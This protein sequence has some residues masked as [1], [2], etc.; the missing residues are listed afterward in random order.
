MEKKKP[1]KSFFKLGGGPLWLFILK[2]QGDLFLT[3]VKILLRLKKKKIGLGKKKKRGGDRGGFTPS[4]EKV[5]GGGG[6][7]LK[8][9]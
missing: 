2:F 8:M 3:S 6:E 4:G 5:R 7:T 9:E 1:L